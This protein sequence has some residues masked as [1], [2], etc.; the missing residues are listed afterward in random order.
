MRA[1]RSTVAAEGDASESEVGLSATQH[2]CGKHMPQGHDPDLQP[3]SIGDKNIT[4]LT[5]IP[6][7]LF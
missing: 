3:L 7:E 1:S 2:T 5:L 6:D 4:Y